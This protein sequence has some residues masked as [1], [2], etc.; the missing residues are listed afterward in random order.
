MDL[1]NLSTPVLTKLYECAKHPSKGARPFFRDPRNMIELRNLLAL[2]RRVEKSAVK[3]GR[4]G[5]GNENTRPNHLSE[6]NRH[7]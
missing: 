2:R 3:A 4:S 5:A 7:A 1:S 6:G